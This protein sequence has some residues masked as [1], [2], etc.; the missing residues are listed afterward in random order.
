[1]EMDNQ[2]KWGIVGAILVI[3]GFVLISYNFVFLGPYGAEDFEDPHRF[4]LHNCDEN[5][6]HFVYVSIINSNGTGYNSEYNHLPGQYLY[7]TV[8]NTERSN[9]DLDFYFTADTKSPT[10]LRE[11]VAPRAPFYFDICDSVRNSSVSDTMFHGDYL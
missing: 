8:N 9:Q 1:M 6:S 5:L 4:G 11:R 7:S 2:D 3:L 10:H